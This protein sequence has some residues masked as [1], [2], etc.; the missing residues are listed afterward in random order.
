ME[1]E[2]IFAVFQR[3][4]EKMFTLTTTVVQVHDQNIKIF[5]QEQLR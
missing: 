1:M 3:W 4:T 5:G 2:P